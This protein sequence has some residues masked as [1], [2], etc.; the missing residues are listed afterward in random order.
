MF[1]SCKARMWSVLVKS[2]GFFLVYTENSKS[3]F[4][5]RI[6]YKMRWK[7]NQD[8]TSIRLYTPQ[9]HKNSLN[10]ITSSPPAILPTDFCLLCPFCLLWD[11]HFPKKIASFAH[12]TL[13]ADQH[14]IGMIS[15]NFHFVMKL[16]KFKISQTIQYTNHFSLKNLTFSW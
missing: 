6:F 14:K 12:K 8:I 7:I 13:F 9:F 2:R 15:C 3:Q 1:A 11:M 5:E 10:C 16:W 4:M